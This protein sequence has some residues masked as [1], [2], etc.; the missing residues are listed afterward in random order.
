M[1][2]PTRA[3]RFEARYGVSQ[4]VIDL[5]AKYVNRELED[6]EVLAPND[7]EAKRTDLHQA[8]REKWE[9][10]QLLLAALPEHECRIVQALLFRDIYFL[11][12]LYVASIRQ[13][14]PEPST[15][16]ASSTHGKSPGAEPFSEWLFEIH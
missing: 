6:Y 4:A 15:Q 10:L 11:L 3:R 8:S 9:H 16:A 7:V 13:R 2:R 5:E 1:G 14:H 12:E